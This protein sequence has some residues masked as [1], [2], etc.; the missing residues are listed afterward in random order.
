MGARGHKNHRCT[1]WFK[2]IS[3]KRDNDDFF[4]INPK[5]EAALMG[6]N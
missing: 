1:T 6:I 2:G 3:P 5:V 4:P